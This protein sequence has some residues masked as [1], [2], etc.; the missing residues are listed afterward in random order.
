MNIFGLLFLFLITAQNYFPFWQ[1]FIS[2][3]FF[4][5][6]YLVCSFLSKVFYPTVP[7]HW[8]I[9][10]PEGVRIYLH[11]KY[12]FQNWML[13]FIFGLL[14]WLFFTSLP[15]VNLSFCLKCRRGVMWDSRP[16]TESK[17]EKRGIESEKHHRN[18]STCCAWSGI[19]KFF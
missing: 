10:P 17:G 19:C 3:L 9:P 16:E 8:I 11:M 14:D 12:N 13:T 6:Y 7:F 18:V 2:L 15:W 1:L 5:L 4:V